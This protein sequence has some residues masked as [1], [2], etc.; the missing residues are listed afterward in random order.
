MSP[1]AKI[2]PYRKAVAALVA[3]PLTVAWLAVDPGSLAGATID[4][5]EWLGIVFAALV[6]TGAVYAVPNESV[7]VAPAPDPGDGF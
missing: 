1:L 3:G 7:T 5:K 4:V 6:P 2:A